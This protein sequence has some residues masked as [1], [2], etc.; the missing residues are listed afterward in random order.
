MGPTPLPPA[1]C[2]PTSS[3]LPVRTGPGPLPLQANANNG[4]G[5]Q[6]S[7]SGSVPGDSKRASTRRHE[8]SARPLSRVA[9]GF[10]PPA[11]APGQ[12]RGDIRRVEP[13]PASTPAL[14]ALARQYISI[15]GRECFEHHHA[16]AREPVLQLDETLGLNVEARPGLGLPIMKFHWSGFNVNNLIEALETIERRD[17]SR[18]AES[19]P[20]LYTSS[21]LGVGEGTGTVKSFVNMLREEMLIGDWIFYSKF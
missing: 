21:P 3:P 7:Q 17:L 13:E 6:R 1:A 19:I 9:G 12:A 2:A 15:Q 5:D 10:R 11:A 4:S 18:K 14:L 8:P 20:W 16:P